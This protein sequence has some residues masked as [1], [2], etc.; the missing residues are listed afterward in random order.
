VSRAVD[1]AV[2]RAKA[3]AMAALGDVPGITVEEIEGGIVA[4]GRR[5]KAR[6]LSDARLRWLGG[7][8]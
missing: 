8:M 1:A 4:T 7:W 6:W 2:A 5:L 3:R